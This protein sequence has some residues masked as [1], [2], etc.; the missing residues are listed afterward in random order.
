M[1]GWTKPSGYFEVELTGF[2]P[3]DV[4]DGQIQLRFDPVAIPVGEDKLVPTLTVSRAGLSEL[5]S[6]L[7][8]LAAD[9]PHSHHRH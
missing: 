7:K 2:Q 4:G 1:A 8:L 3:L 6:R 5:A 9:V